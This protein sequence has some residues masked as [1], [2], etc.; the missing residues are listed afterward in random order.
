[1]RLIDMVVKVWVAFSIKDRSFTCF[2]SSACMFMR[3][4]FYIRCDFHRYTLLIQRDVESL[5]IFKALSNSSHIISEMY[6]THYRH[7]E[8]TTFKRFAKPGK[9]TDPI[10]TSGG[11]TFASQRTLHHL[12]QNCSRI[13]LHSL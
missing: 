9:E 11:D 10:F 7:R 1:M 2:E 4:A 12:L 5:T 3:D 6:C 8:P 13:Y